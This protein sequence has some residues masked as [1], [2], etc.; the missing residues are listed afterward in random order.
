MNGTDTPAES[1]Q[2]VKTAITHDRIIDFMLAN[3]EATNREVAAQ[4]GFQ[5]Q[6]ISIIINSDAFQARYTKRKTE[7]IDPILAA[8]IESRLKVLAAVSA[9]IVAEQLELNR[10][11]KKFALEVL[12]ASTKGLGLGL[13]KQAVNAVQA[14]FVVSLPGPAASSSEWMSKFAPQNGTMIVPS[15]A[16]APNESDP[17]PQALIV[18]VVPI[19]R[20][21]P[22]A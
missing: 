17:V 15:G 16:D 8:S 11:D 6:S 2:R 7:L 12:Q 18:D 20:E 13:P 4:F 10:T 21:T 1:K 3:P 14:N 9:E 19:A 22:E 5:P